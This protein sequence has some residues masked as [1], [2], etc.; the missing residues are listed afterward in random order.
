L[1][2]TCYFITGTDT[3]I[4]KTTVTC[5]LAAALTERGVRVGVMKPIETGCEVDSVG[6]RV[7]ADAVRLEYFSR[8]AEPLERVCPVRLRDPLAPSVAARREGRTVDIDALRDQ[9]E[10][11]AS[12]YDVTLVEGAG[13]LLVPIRDDTTFVDLARD[14]GIPVLIVVGN[15]LGALNHA[16]LTMRCAQA[17]DL[18]VVGYVVNTLAPELDV[19]AQSNIE[20]LEKLIGP[21][22]GVLP[23]LGR[24]DCS[25]QDRER[26]AQAAEEAFDVSRFLRA[27]GELP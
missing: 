18:S 6:N 7:A 10:S 11:L 22:L 1:F 24:I 2:G 13:G 15:R 27:A 8:C 4:G 5:A 20:V 16:Q 25:P 14:W 21:S 19:A 3:G 17:E 12:D 26:L 23:W 9:L